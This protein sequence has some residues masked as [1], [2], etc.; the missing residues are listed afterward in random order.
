MRIFLALLPLLI[1]APAAAAPE[2]G[3]RTGQP[4]QLFS[5]I[6]EGT[7]DSAL[8]AEIAAAAAHPLGS[9]ANPVRVGGPEGER[10]YIARLRCA[11]GSRPQIGARADG[12]V[13][14]FGSVVS[15]YPLDC[16]AAAPGRTSL[17]LDMYH[18]EHREDRAPAGFAI[19]AR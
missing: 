15:V 12:G 16:G 10:A 7:S 14:G 1:A 13:G 19:V 6:G 2:L 8:E 5:G 3:Q 4:E 18:E 17:M 11:D 9:L